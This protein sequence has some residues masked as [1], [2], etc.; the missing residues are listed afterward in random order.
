MGSGQSTHSQGANTTSGNSGTIVYNY[1]QQHYQNSIDLSGALS[2]HSVG[3]GDQSS[4]SSKIEKSESASGSEANPMLSVIGSAAASALLADLETEETTTLGDRVATYAS[5]NTAQN[6]Q[7][8]VGLAVAYGRP[9]AGPPSSTADN[10]TKGVK[11]VERAYTRRLIDWTTSQK[12]YQYILLP[13]PGIFQD[14][15]FN[16]MILQHYLVKTGYRVQVQCNASIFHAGCLYVG[17]VPEAVRKGLKK[18]LETDTQWQTSDT[19]PFDPQQL[20]VFPHQ[21]LNLRTNNAVDIRVPYVNVCPASCPKVHS[22]WSLLIAVL[23]PLA[24]ATGSSPTVSITASVVPQDF[25]ANGLRQAVGEGMVVTDSAD[26]QQVGPEPTDQTPA[27]VPGWRPPTDFLGGEVTDYMQIARIPTFAVCATDDEPY[28]EVSN[29]VAEGPVFSMDVAISSDHLAHTSLWGLALNFSQYR[30]TLDLTFTFTGAAAARGK[31]LIAYIPPGAEPNDIDVAQLATNLIWDIGLNSTVKFSVPFISATDFRYCRALP[32]ATT[33]DVDGWVQVYQLTPVTY[34]AGAP[35]AA[36]VLVMASAGSDFTLR[37]PLDYY[38]GEE[39]TEEKA[40]TDNAEKG[41]VPDTDA[42]DMIDAHPVSRLEVVPHTNLRFLLDRFFYFETVAALPLLGQE[43]SKVDDPVRLVLDPARSIRQ[44]NDPVTTL[45]RLLR[46]LTYFS[47]DL[48]LWVRPLAGPLAPKSLTLQPYTSSDA[49]LSLPNQGPAE[50]FASLDSNLDNFAVRFVPPGG[51]VPLGF[52]KTDNRLVA[53]SSVNTNSALQ[54]LVGETSTPELRLTVNSGITGGLDPVVWSSQGASLNGVKFSVPYS[55]LYSAQCT[56]FNG[57]SS[58]AKSVFGAPPTP[59]YG[60]L[61][62][63][64]QA[65]LVK[66]LVEMRLRGLR[67][68]CPRPFWTPA[69]TFEASRNRASAEDLELLLGGDIETNPGPVMSTLAGSLAGSA[70][71]IAVALLKARLGVSRLTSKKFWL[72][73]IKTIAQLIGLISAARHGDWVGF[74]AQLVALG[75]DHLGSIK[76]LFRKIAEKCGLIVADNPPPRPNGRRTKIPQLDAFKQ[77]FSKIFEGFRERAVNRLAGAARAEPKRVVTVKSLWP[78][79]FDDVSEH[80]EKWG[81][82]NPFF[83]YQDDDSDYSDESLEYTPED[84]SSVNQWFNLAKNAHWLLQQIAN[85]IEWLRKKIVPKVDAKE[86]CISTY[87]SSFSL[88]CQP[89]HQHKDF[90][91]KQHHACVRAGLPR[92]ADHW[93]EAHKKADLRARPEP[94]CLV[95][96]GKPGQGKSVTASLIAKA[97][98]ALMTGEARVWSLPTDSDHFDGYANQYSVIID[99]LGQNPDGNDYKSFCQMVSS[100]PFI[101]PMASLNEKG[102]PFTSPFIVVTTNKPAGYTPPTISEPAALSRRFTFEY[103]VYAV[104]GFKRNGCLNYEAAV[105]PTLEIPDLDCFRNDC[106][107]LN[108]TAVGFARSQGARRSLVS[109]SLYAVVREC[110]AELTRRAKVA[111]TADLVPE[112]DSSDDDESGSESDSEL[113]RADDL[114]RRLQKLTRER[115][116]KQFKAV[117]RRWASNISDADRARR[118]GQDLAIGFSVIGTLLIAVYAAYSIY[119]AKKFW[120]GLEELDYENPLASQGPYDGGAVRNRRKTMQLRAEDGGVLDALMDNCVPVTFRRTLDDGRVRHNTCTGFFLRGRCLVVPNHSFSK[121]WQHLHVCGFVFPRSEILSCAFTMGGLE[122]D[123]LV[124]GLPRRFPCTKDRT[125]LLSDFTPTRGASLYVLVNNEQR[126]RN[127]VSATFISTRD[128]VPIIGNRVFPSVMAYSCNT[129]P[130]FCASPVVAKENGRYVIVGFHCA[131]N[132]TIG[133]ASRVPKQ[134]IMQAVTSLEKEISQPELPPDEISSSQP[135]LDTVVV[136]DEH[137]VKTWNAEKVSFI[138][139]ET[140]LRPSPTYDGICSHEPAVLSRADPRLENPDFEK[141][142]LAKNDIMPQPCDPKL[143]PVLERAA[144]DYAASLFSVVG[145][146]NGAVSIQE[147]IQGYDTLEGLDM[148]TSPGLPYTDNGLRRQD[149]IKQDEDG[150]YVLR[151]DLEKRVETFLSGDYSSHVFQS[152]LKDELRPVAK[153]RAGATRVVEVAA[154]DHVIVGRVLLSK[155]TNKLM[156]HNGTSTGSAIGVDPDVDWTRYYMEFSEFPYV[157]DFDYKAFDSSHSKLIFEI[158]RDRILTPGNGFDERVREYIDS[159]CFSTHRF[160]DVEYLTDGALPSGCSGTTV[161]NNLFNNVIVRAVLRK[162]YTG[163]DEGD[164]AVVCYG[165]D[166][167]LGSRIPLDLDRMVAAFS[168][169]G[170]TVT[171]ADKS[172]VFNPLSTIDSVTFLKRKFVKDPEH[173]FLIHPV[174]DISLLMQLLKWQRRGEFAAKVRSIAG[175]AWHSGPADYAI[176]VEAVRDYAYVPSFTSLRADW[177]AEFGIN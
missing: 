168:E 159:L 69:R 49:G 35:T 177:L 17:L 2:S 93:L 6:T 24:Y 34:P 99:D 163:W 172:G 176:L 71:K 27:Y 132:G 54:F 82:G 42:S 22:P 164:I 47:S 28:F 48:G 3:S 143:R 120:D 70:G 142:L 75:L 89:T 113:G 72:K 23:S 44:T 58:F 124:L 21:L 111:E 156:I 62:I 139:R 112:D 79:F 162:L 174:M 12:H 136:R 29:T 73:M 108:G 145:Y 88:L 158:V 114:R 52:S 123:A 36:K 60:S 104:D 46:P 157:Y 4:G 141:D 45:E 117:F 16:S 39:G 154:V 160:G 68:W 140:S 50:R 40:V 84:L 169:L 167:L 118:F 63:Y 56:A 126:K 57:Y 121:D 152:F 15:M 135:D 66:F 14:G 125:N 102:T 91:L 149:L 43:G 129:E 103:D 173:P 65:P 130:G 67:A 146:D 134:F 98:S 107:L 32:E 122:S 116:R 165:D 92:L 94:V 64:A 10:P 128:T 38:D 86:A 133:F 106:P 81:V 100:T 150:T 147:A 87:E 151:P 138:P 41:S 80:E 37:Y 78:G 85:A 115:E 59:G 25:I 55:S 61:Q 30:G 105:A 96:R 51:V 119:R 90:F 18:P 8:S 83:P 127:L 77:D 9:D 5:G 11:S 13:L 110:V 144:D 175:L 109:I 97:V 19:L 148:T 7:T 26:R 95:L 161:V 101:P 166:L 153:V 137:I 1:Y 170:Y 31:F 53:Q 131:G 20:T 33:T 76:S 155:F 74:S 171:P